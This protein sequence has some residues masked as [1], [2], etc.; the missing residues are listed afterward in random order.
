MSSPPHRILVIDDDPNILACIEFALIERGYEV[1]LAHD[2]IEGLIRAERDSPDLIV[3]D[4]VMPHHSGLTIL[5]R[6]RK[7]RQQSPRIILLTGNTDPKHKRFA[8]SHGADRFLGKPFDIDHLLK[9]IETLLQDETD[10]HD[11][12]D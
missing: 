6:I 8:E 7:N 1:L 3:L 4:M 2:G 5:D 11:A 10:R 9:E 12:T